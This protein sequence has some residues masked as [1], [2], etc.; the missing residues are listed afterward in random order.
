MLGSFLHFELW[1][2]EQS[3][4]TRI[5]SRDAEEEEEE[6]EEETEE[7]GLLLRCCVNIN[8]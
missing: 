3:L 4:T 5:V 7:A 8:R 1:W 2:S 6:E